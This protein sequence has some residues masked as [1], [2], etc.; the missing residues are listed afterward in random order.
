MALFFYDPLLLFLVLMVFIWSF[1]F[2]LSFVS[3]ED[4]AYVDKLPTFERNIDSFAGIV[5]ERQR[6][7]AGSWL[8]KGFEPFV[9][10]PT[11]SALGQRPLLR[12]VIVSQKT[13]V[14]GWLDWF[15]L[16]IFWFTPHICHTSVYRR[17]HSQILQ[18]PN[19]YFFGKLNARRCREIP[20][21]HFSFRSYL[22][23]NHI[24]TF[25]LV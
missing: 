25:P 4:D 5:P 22:F 12:C 3:L 21:L 13:W 14:L 11:Q 10:G 6:G 19:T 1:V 15:E 23:P 9:M 2:I 16:S 20:R 8:G 7:E 18:Y 24:H 17:Y